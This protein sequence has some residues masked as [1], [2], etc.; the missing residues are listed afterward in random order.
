M[1]T[2]RLVTVFRSIPCIGGGGVGAGCRLSGHVTCD[3]SWEANQPPSPVDKHLW[4]HYLA[5]NLICG[6]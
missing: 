6:R 1:R 2:A 5:Q 3:A 4:K